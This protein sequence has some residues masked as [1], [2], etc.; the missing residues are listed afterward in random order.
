MC[1]ISPNEECTRII[2]FLNNRK[3]NKSFKNIHLVRHSVKEFHVPLS[4]DTPKNVDKSFIPK[5]FPKDF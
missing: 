1:N 5:T 2:G 3:Y 4:R